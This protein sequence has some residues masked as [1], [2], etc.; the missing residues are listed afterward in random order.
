M[1]SF[2]LL[3]LAFVLAVAVPACSS[4]HSGDDDSSAGNPKSTAQASSASVAITAADGGEVA[5]GDAKLSIPGGALADDTTVTVASS[6]PSSS[7]P[8][9]SS[10]QGLVYDF[11]PTGTTFAKPVA[12]TLPL[13]KSP[14]DGKEAV[15]SYLNEDTNSWEDLTTTTSAGV[16]SADI[17]HFSRYVVA[18]PQCQRHHRRRGL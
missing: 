16:V 12:L 11:G 1:R 17:A 8:E 2:R 13:A 15:I 10:V 3:P 6:Q 7:L 18:H 9:A 5:L 4:S 14:G